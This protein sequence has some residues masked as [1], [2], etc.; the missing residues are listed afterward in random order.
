MVPA[1]LAYSGA[2][3]VT[4]TLLTLAVSSLSP[5]PALASVHLFV[6]IAVTGAVAELLAGLTRTHAW[7]LVSVVANLRQVRSWCFGKA[8]PYDVSPWATLAVL[9]LLLLACAALLRA[10]VR[11]VDVVGGA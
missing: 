10:R 4:A 7:Q 1:I 3:I 9:V 6:F 2:L 11:A 5:S 8:L